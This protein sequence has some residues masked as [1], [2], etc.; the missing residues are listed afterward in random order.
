[1]TSTVLQSGLCDP[2]REGGLWLGSNYWNAT[3]KAEPS[4][5]SVQS[6]TPGSLAALMTL[7]AQDRLVDSQS[8]REMRL[9]LQKTPF[10]THPTIVSWFEEGLNEKSPGLIRLALSKLGVLDGIDDCAY[11]ERKLSSASAKILRYVAVGVRARSKE[12][13]KMKK[14]IKLLD[15]CI[16][17]NNP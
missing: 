4:R 15:D 17:A 16:V 3:W 7:M 9:L 5:G 6:A 2:A 1:M 14:L 13:D 11:F 8:S 10:P 12:T